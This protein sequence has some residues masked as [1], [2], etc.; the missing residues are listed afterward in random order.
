LNKEQLQTIWKALL[1][2]ERMKVNDWILTNTR[3]ERASF[4]ICNTILEDEGDV[5]ES[6]QK[7]NLS[8]SESLPKYSM[9]K[10][11]LSSNNNTLLAAV[12][13]MI[14]SDWCCANETHLD[15]NLIGLDHALACH[16]EDI[17][18]RSVPI[19]VSSE[20][21]SLELIMGEIDKRISDSNV[22]AV[23]DNLQE[24]KEY[25][26]LLKSGENDKGSILT[27]IGCSSYT[28]SESKQ[29][30]IAFHCP[31]CNQTFPTMEEVHVGAV[32]FL[33]GA[34]DYSTPD[35]ENVS[36]KCTRCPGCEKELPM[37]A[38]EYEI[39]SHVPKATGVT[40][41]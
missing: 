12:N 41:G 2:G 16:L 19:L 6:I 26:Y 4:D 28:S 8:E 21:D 7:Q 30:A 18:G 1:P 35:Y 36:F 10:D 40:T 15:P 14:C 38:E 20:P 25:V 17:I 3:T 32:Y 24:I 37:R 22:E 11:I 27:P 29:S 13:C 23:N 33:M 34:G 39:K 5:H 9:G 31:E